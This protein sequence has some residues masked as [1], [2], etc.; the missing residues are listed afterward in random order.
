M[1][2]SC[3]ESCGGKCCK[4]ELGG[5]EGFVFLTQ[6]DERR[7]TA[8]SKKTFFERGVFSS[9]RFIDKTTQQTYLKKNDDGSCIFFKKGKCIIYEARPTQCRTFPFWPELVRNNEQWEK[10]GQACPGIGNGETQSTDL[11]FQ[12][13]EADKELCSHLV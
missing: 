2:F 1:R 10:V 9:T 4:V 11:L 3:Q 13:M 12:Q 7:L 8:L 5:K 6:Q